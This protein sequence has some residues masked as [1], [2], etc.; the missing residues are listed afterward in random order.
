MAEKASQRDPAK[1]E[2]RDSKHKKGLICHLFFEDRRGTTSQGMS[3][4]SKSLEQPPSKS[5]KKQV[6]QSY[7]HKELN[8]ANNLNE[9]GSI[10]SPELPERN[11][12][13]LTPEF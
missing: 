4:A 7:N 3:A 1:K 10:S 6:P 9:Y 12:A 13:L 2:A 5:A 11:T 8:L